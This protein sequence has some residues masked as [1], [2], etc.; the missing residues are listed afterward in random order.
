MVPLHLT[1]S[2]LGS[3]WVALRKRMRKQTYV[4]ILMWKHVSVPGVYVKEIVTGCSWTKMDLFLIYK[5]G[6]FYQGR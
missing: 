5:A 4:R 1:G 2:L 6:V 3:R